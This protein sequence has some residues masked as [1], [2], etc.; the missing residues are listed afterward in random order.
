[1]PAFLPTL[2][3]RPFASPENSPKLAA[4]HGEYVYR[5]RS[6]K[7]VSMCSDPVHAFSEIKDIRASV[8]MAEGKVHSPNISRR[9]AYR[10]R[11]VKRSSQTTGESACAGSLHSARRELNLENDSGEEVLAYWPDTELRSSP[12]M[13]TPIKRPLA[14]LVWKNR[15]Q[16][17]RARQKTAWTLNRR[18]GEI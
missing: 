14:G 12:F 13:S 18:F 16:T 4:T 11:M 8:Q 6:Q 5:I 15:M 10:A 3:T 1:M 9:L 2:R 17:V 7:V